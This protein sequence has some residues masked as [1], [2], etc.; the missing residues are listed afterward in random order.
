MTEGQALGRLLRICA[1]LAAVKASV[2]ADAAPPVGSEAHILSFVQHKANADLLRLSVPFARGSL[3][4]SLA[5]TLAELREQA[6][7]VSS[8]G[9]GMPHLQG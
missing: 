7:P 8:T 6:S 1:V 9:Q 2:A 5:T 3:S 4:A